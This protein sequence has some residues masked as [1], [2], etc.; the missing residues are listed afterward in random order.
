[1]SALGEWSPGRLAQRIA[2][3]VRRMRARRV[4]AAKPQP[5]R[6]HLGCGQVHFPGWIHL[7][8]N[9]QLPHLDV[10]WHATDGLPC[11]DQS[12]EFIHSEHFFEHLSDADGRFLWSE[13]FRVLKPDGVVRV[14]MPDL[15]T[16][17]E[18]YSQGDWR[19]QAWIRDFGYSH[20]KTGCEMLN[21][22]FRNWEHLWLYDREE[23]HRRLTDAGFTHIVDVRHG[24]SSHPELQNRETRPDSLLVCE[25]SP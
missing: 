7:D 14:A 10:L 21:I 8:A 15:G 5:Y 3:R 4:M 9:P 24:E 17:I 18:K 13:C 19:D 23:L 2:G 6:L 11:P 20:L 25:A 1:M 12:C 22:V 16:F